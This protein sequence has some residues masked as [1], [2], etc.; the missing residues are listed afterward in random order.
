MVKLFVSFITAHAISLLGCGDIDDA[1]SYF[2]KIIKEHP[3]VT[4]AFLGR[5]T[6]YVKKG[7][8]IKENSDAAISDFSTVISHSPKNPEG[9]IRRAEVLSPIGRIPEAIKDISVA[10]SLQPSAELYLISGTLHFMSEDYVTATKNLEKSLEY[11]PS[12]ATATLYLGLSLYHRGLIQ[13]AIPLYKKALQANTNTAEVHRSLGHAYRELGDASAAY[14]HFTAALLLEPRSAETFHLRGMLQY[15]NGKPALA[16]NDFKACQSFD[17]QNTA[18]LYMKAVCYATLGNFYETV[19][20]ST[21]VRLHLLYHGGI[22]NPIAVK[23]Q[24]LKEYSRYL[25]SHLDTPLTSFT[26]DEGLDG[27]LR[28]HWVK[29]L[30]FSILNYTEQPGI[31]PSIRE[32]ESLP[33]EEYSTDAKTI[34]C[35]SQLLGPLVQYHT[36]GFLP[37]TRHHRAMGLAIL[38]VAQAAQRHWKSVRSSKASDKS[39]RLSWRAMFDVAV[40][41]RRLV[42]PDQAVMWLDK[43]PQKSVRAGFNVHMTLVRG[44]MRNVRY[45]D[46]F[47]KIFQFTKKM[48]LHFYK[49]EEF[50]TKDFKRRIEKSRTCEDLISALKVQ[51]PTNPQPGLMLSTHVTSLLTAGKSNLDGVILMLSEG[52]GK[53]LVFSMDTPTTPTRTANYHSELEFLWNQIRDEVRKPSNK[54]RYD[55][56]PLGVYILSFAYYFLNLMP[57]SRG[58]SAVAYT[59]ALGLFLAAGKEA[60]GNIPKGKEVDLEA[61]IGGTADKFAK[62]VQAWLALKK[63]SPSLTSFPSVRD[64]FPTLRHALEA[65]NVD[66]EAEHCKRHRP[67]KSQ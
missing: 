60:T 57:L 59:V 66:V 37:S 10:L 58:T 62:E 41:W 28:D 26:P 3:K 43:M 50:S 21:K 8:Q 6:A 33:F 5:G 54:V 25:H 51:N 65:L 34:L 48:L 19:K 67:R 44:Q 4:S 64:T 53:N 45:S 29:S 20:M 49:T 22:M 40:K 35:K 42:D 52:S 46:Y 11:N 32:V 39:A 16:L 31:Q 61:M 1:I 38:D 18:C 14:E 24:F 17:P 56:D 13:Q 55:S 2:T 12:Q 27:N 36:D 47:E 9:W 63:A 23:A 30:P 7:I 15:M